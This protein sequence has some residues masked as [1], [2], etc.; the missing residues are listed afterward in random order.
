[1]AAMLAVLPFK[2]RISTAHTSNVG[3]NLVPSLI[4][5]QETLPDNRKAMPAEEAT[6]FPGSVLWYLATRLTSANSGI[7]MQEN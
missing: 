4:R 5:R 2:K 3:T 7:M 6:S 1:M